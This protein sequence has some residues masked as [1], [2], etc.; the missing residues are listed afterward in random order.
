MNIFVKVKKSGSRKELA[1]KELQLPDSLITLRGLI[2][3]IVE[4]EIR[5]YIDRKQ[6]HTVYRYLTEQQLISAA[7]T[8]KIGFGHI[9]N[10]HIPDEQQAVERAW[11]A[12][13][14]GLYRVFLREQELQQLD[15]SIQL[16]EGDLLTF[17]RFTMLTG[18]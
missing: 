13:E 7:E 8:G 17:I 9:A 2:E 11:L 15:E 18:Y 12:Y 16:N 4:Q 14:D 5:A 1:Q 10:E 3:C 6:Q